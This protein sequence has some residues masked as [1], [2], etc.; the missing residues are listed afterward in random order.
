MCVGLDFEIRV[1]INNEAQKRQ[2]YSDILL[3]HVKM[4]AFPQIRRRKR[5][6]I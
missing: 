2:S 3:E 4:L 1:L 6:R 5:A